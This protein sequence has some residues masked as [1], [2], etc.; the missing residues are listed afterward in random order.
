MEI[1]NH[2]KI[3]RIHTRSHSGVNGNQNAA[4]SKSSEGVERSEEVKPQRLLERLKGNAEVRNRLLVE[5]QAKVQAG[6]YATRVA[7]ER[8]AEQ[9]VGL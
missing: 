8:A 9:I 1:H 6:E 5:I 4:E 7:A 3:L 2:G